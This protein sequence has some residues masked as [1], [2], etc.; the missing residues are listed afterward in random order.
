MDAEASS[1][2]NHLPGF[3]HRSLPAVVPTL[4]I[5]IGYV[6]PGKWAAMV[7]GGARFGFGLMAFMLIFNFAAI[8]CQ[9]ISARIGIITGKDL[10]QICSD[11]YDTWTCML[12]GIQ[13]EI[14]MIML[15]L[16]MILGM[17]QGLNL[18]FG[19][20]LFACVF[21]TATGAVFHLLLA[22]L[23]DIKKAK[24][25]GL[26]VTGFV[27][28]SFVLGVLIN[29][30]GIPLSMNGVL[31]KL[32]GESAFVLMS[33]LGATLVPHNLYLHSSVVQWHQGPTDISKEALCHNHFLAIL[34]FF[35]GLYLVNN[36]VM[37]AS[38]NEFYSTG[39]V[40]LTFQD[41]LSPMEQV[42]RSPIALFA[43]LLILFLANQATALT[44][45]LGG[46][47]VVHGF[48]RLDIPGWLHY[49]T[50]RVIAVLPALYCVW[51]SGAEGI[52][53][54]VIVT[55]VLV[56]LQLP[57][58][59]I[60]LFRVATS[61]SI[62]GV[63]KI[64]QFV[65]LLALV[66]FVGVLGLN[67][68]F[69]V[70]MV[71]GSSEWVGDL[72]WNAGNGVSS[73]YLILYASAVASICFMLWLA[74]TPLRSASVQLE[75]Q[76]WNWDTPETVSNQ[77]VDGEESYLTGTKHHGVT[78]VQVKDPAPAPALTL[79]RTLEYSDVT[80]PR[81][82]HDIPETIM[83]PDLHVSAEKET[84]STTSFPSSPKSL[85]KVSASTSESE[86]VSTVVDEVS[87]SRSED[88]KCVK[89]ETS[90]PVGKSVEFVGDSNAERDDDDDVDSWETEESSKVVSASA[91][92]STSDGPASFRSLSRKSDEGGNSIG[93][94]SRL[95]GLGRA[96]RRQLAAVLD[97]FWGQLYDFHGQATREAKAKKLDALLGGGIDS[98]ST[99]SLQQ[100][101]A[102]GKEYSEYSASVG[103]RASDTSMNSGLYDS[104]KQPRMQS[105]LESSYGLQR[106]SSS[107]QAQLLDAY[108]QSQNSSRNLLDS[109]ERRY[110][111]VRN[112]PSS[113]AW[114]YQPATIHGY[115][116]ASYLN[117]VS[118]DRNFDNLNVSMGSSSLKSPSTDTNYRG[119]LAL[120]LGRKLH[121]GAGIGQPPGF[122]HVAVSRNS[123]L[124][125]ERSYYDFGS[126][127][128]A[129]NAASSI[130]NK[131]Y[132]SLPDISGY[133]IPRRTGYVSEKNAP[134]NGSVGYGS[135]ASK[136]Y[137]PSL[138]SNSGSRIGHPLAFDELSPS[139]VY[140]EALSSQLSSGFDT[141]SLWCR[142]PFEQF[143]VAEKF[144]NVAMDGVG[145][146]PNA[147]AQETTS[148][149]D[150]EAKLLQSV[151]L[152]IVK[153]LKLEGSDWLFR[154][155]DG[156]DED[157][158][159]RVA[160]REKFLYEVE[161]REM[162]QVA[163]MGETQYFSSDGKPGSSIRHDDANSSSFSVS[164]V[165]NCG[166]GCIWR[167]DLIISF[168]VWSIHRILDLSLMESRPELWGK[169][170][171]VLNRLQGIIDPAFS[172]PRSPMVPCF[173][174]QVPVSHQ[175][176]S[177]PP[178][179]NG[180]LPPTSKPG[181]GKY[182]TASMLLEV[183]K[184]VEIAISTRKGRSGTAAG[185]V[186]FPKG[187]ENLASVLKRY[188][189]RLSYKP[190]AIH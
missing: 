109:G 84:Q 150:I 5:S 139:K 7:E 18:I 154:Q 91:P 65:E 23:L 13:A 31:T 159:D 28:L 96:A 114:D 90:A 177:S 68:V 89:I 113:E 4:L 64:S 86:A 66:I 162:N 168:G 79:E 75:A 126:S 12:L 160:A 146:R 171:Y 108:V 99:G 132:H 143:G 173:C 157:L 119:S 77:P 152:C 10:A 189:R 30:P 167:S 32:N 69:V 78:S 170:T 175:Q 179:S 190:A 105:S 19:W 161:T 76:V 67:I 95:A 14:S 38:A 164:S 36:V 183:V 34:C 101:D 110:S 57:S 102:C 147:A 130:N 61:R 149:V 127:V 39:L 26:Y 81:F 33:L 178:Q 62:M 106:S 134:W 42:L 41:A 37:N 22:L 11:E 180:M 93:S 123:Q 185:D 186:A 121:N 138:Y 20:D 142:Q 103:G 115:Q 29:Q 15:D 80:V 156:I 120:A 2:T 140:R 188:K 172:K 88:T 46:E 6:D 151:R 55:Q 133:A 17:A 141:G 116:S 112:L 50:I 136:T 128:S 124:Q 144:N 73:S 27:L 104:L 52:Y 49:A 60:P 1:T 98:R 87:D 48:L 74:V 94:L 169:Y 35:S 118:K 165:P 70:E 153:L 100:V 43:F 117:R 47:V 83:E 9:Y 145:I 82:H 45:S 56:A 184:D 8:F 51:S 72:R 187:K 3:L 137:E 59:V 107:I 181:R 182:T 54:L 44:W 40:L 25:V 111:S 122:Q 135:S 174:L 71:F 58:S 53:Q 85:A 166:E 63:H 131:K 16:N 155:N 148:F 97:E 125:S 129:D 176:K 21:L 158:V 163:H 92:S 24:I